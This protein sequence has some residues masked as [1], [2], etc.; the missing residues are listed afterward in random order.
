MR[1]TTEIKLANLSDL[2]L[3]QMGA[4]GPRRCKATHR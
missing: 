1:H 4:M 2:F 3:V